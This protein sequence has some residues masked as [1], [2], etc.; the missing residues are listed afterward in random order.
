MTDP[1]SRPIRVAHL[2]QNLNYG[3]MEQVLHN[4]ARRLPS[5]GFEVH[6]V[7]LQYLGHFAGGLEEKATLHQVPPMPRWS[8][9]H[10][11]ALITTLRSIDPDVVHSHT[12]VWFKAARAARAADVGVVVHT[13]HGRP[14]PVPLADRLIDNTASRWTDRVIAVSSALANVLRAQVVHDSSAVT[15]ITNGV[16]VDALHPPADRAMLRR[17]LDLPVDAP[18][19]GSIGRLEPIKNYQLA[20][21]ALAKLDTIAGSERAP[22]LVLA[23]DGSARA[24]L[25]ALARELGVSDRVKFLGWRNDPERLYGCFDVFTLSSLSEGTSISLLESMS[26]GVCPAVTDVGGNR[27]A[28][29]PGLSSLLVPSE[30]VDRL[31]ELWRRLLSDPVERT[32]LGERARARVIEQFSLDRMVDEHVALYRDLLDRRRN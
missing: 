8:M 13:E 25:E 27:A 15:V 24:G 30:D 28:L 11:G 19:I 17:S 4:L 16:D 22:V 6:V 18:I 32:R 10:P 14:D 20:L 9:L 7:V 12:G 26:C 2:I 1:S 5:R 3:G 31:A 29:G 23:G 21:R